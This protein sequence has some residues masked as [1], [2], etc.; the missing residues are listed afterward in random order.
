MV[1]RYGEVAAWAREAGYDGVQLASSNAK[2]LDQFLSPFYNRRTD[3]FGGSLENAGPRAAADPRARSP[4]GPAPTSRARSRCRWRRR[5]R[6]SRPAP[7]R[8][9]GVA[10]RPL[11]EEWGFDAVTPVEVS[12][13]PDTTL[14]RGGVPT[15]SGRTRRM[16]TRLRDG[17]RPARV[18]AAVLQAGYVVGGAPS[19]FKPVWN[20]ALFHGREARC[21]HPGARGRR[22]PH[23]REVD[24]ILDDGEADMVGIG[25]PFY[26][27]PDLAR[28]ILG[29]RMPAPRV[30]CQNSNLCVPAQMLGHEGRLLQPRGQEGPRRPPSHTQPPE[31]DAIEGVAQGRLL[32][33]PPL[34]SPGFAWRSRRRVDRRLAFGSTQ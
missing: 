6:R 17:A 9:E 18:D 5:R 20:R 27:E 2:L 24:A 33:S 32:L 11:C 28:R 30:C 14:C 15:R 13:L 7:R 16:K 19:P 4:S 10:P 21:R 34:F 22:H 12:V 1:A 3:E 31:L 23:G 26:A 29:E 25:R 8:D